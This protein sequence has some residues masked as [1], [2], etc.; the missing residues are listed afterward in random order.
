MKE[1]GVGFVQISL[2]G[3]SAHTH[4]SFRGINGMF[5]KTIN[6]IKNCVEENLWVNIA[7]TATKHN[8]KEISKIIDLCENLGVKWFMV[9]N[10]IPTGRGKFILK[11]DLSPKER[12]KL[13]KMLWGRLKS[14]GK[15]DV[16]STAPQF[17]RVALQE[18]INKDKK[19]IPT[20][21]ANPE[22]S[23]KLLHLSEF[24]GGCGCGRFYTAIKPNGDIQPCVFFPLTLG[25][26]KDVDFKKFWRNNIVLKELRKKDILEGN[27]GKCNYRY[28]CGGCRA[29]AYAYT[30]N[31]LAPDPGC[32][33]NI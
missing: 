6:G 5:D 33:K 8:Y 18:E 13:L 17:A 3:A 22:L 7:T 24:I 26:I 15:V 19:I 29:R 12:E 23:D 31:Y 4:D 2:D 28:F 30:G 1:A 25:N 27:C 14:K 10:F 11:N 16:L 32:I 9:Y 21:F 20:H